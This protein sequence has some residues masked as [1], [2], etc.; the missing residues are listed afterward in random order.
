[1]QLVDVLKK[2]LTQ[3]NVAAQSKKRALE[4]ISTEIA[5]TIPGTDPTELFERIMSRERLG[6]TGIGHGIAIPHC[7]TENLPACVAG[8]FRLDAP[9]NFDAIDDQLVDIV[10]VLLVPEDSVDAHL[11]LLANIAE[12][13]DN[14]LLRERLRSASDEA[15][16]YQ[17]ATNYDAR[18]GT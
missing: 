1:M 6:S 17:I 8:L 9:V 12:I 16:L 5:N 11:Q 14:E 2:N 10:L 4:S 7:R 13:F 18:R 15:E 3:V